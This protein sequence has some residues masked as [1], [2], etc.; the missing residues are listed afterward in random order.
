MIIAMPSSLFSDEEASDGEEE[1]ESVDSSVNQDSVD[2]RF[3]SIV[4]AP[5]GPNASHL[6]W[7]L[8]AMVVI[9][10]EFVA[11]AEKEAMCFYVAAATSRL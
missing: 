2:V 6:A 7:N 9:R 10:R 5:G 3:V 11:L 1:V 4:N 8:N